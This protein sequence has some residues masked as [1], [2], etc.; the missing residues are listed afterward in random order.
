MVSV[1]VMHLRGYSRG[2]ENWL[3]RCLRRKRKISLQIDW[4]ETV[5]ALH[6]ILKWNNLLL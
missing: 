2:V 5:S 1:W 3:V 6:S 4:L